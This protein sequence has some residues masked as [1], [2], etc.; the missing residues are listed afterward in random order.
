MLTKANY[1]V[2]CAKTAKSALEILDD[3][4]NIDVIL[5][6]LRLSGNMDGVSLCSKIK[7]KD[8]E[9]IVLVLTDKIDD[10]TLEYCLSIGFRDILL[11]PIKFDE[12][13][14]V[15]NCSFNISKKWKDI[16]YGY[17]SMDNV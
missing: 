7:Y 13:I 12:L 4:N 15:V 5:T 14:P 8:I 10:Y 17:R 11:K 6:D 2:Y 1:E 3:I 9:K 16:S